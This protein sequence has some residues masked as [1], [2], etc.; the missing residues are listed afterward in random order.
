MNLNEI[1]STGGGSNT[2]LWLNP[3]CHNLKADNLVIDTVS[4][5]NLIIQKTAFTCADGLNLPTVAQFI[6]GIFTYAGALACQ[7]RSP[8]SVELAAAFPDPLVTSYFTINTYCT[9]V[10]SL[11]V[12]GGTGCVASNYVG[13]TSGSHSYLFYGNSSGFSI[14]RT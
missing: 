2:K 9:G 11:E 1:N 7:V 10:G 3:V 4:A 8:T 13:G 6:N 5:S 14:L 12:Q